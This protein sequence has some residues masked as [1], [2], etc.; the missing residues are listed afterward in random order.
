MLFDHFYRNPLSFLL[1][2]EGHFLEDIFLEK[3]SSPSNSHL[4]IEKTI[5]QFCKDHEDLLK[6]YFPKEKDQKALENQVICALRKLYQY[7]W[8]FDKAFMCYALL[9]K[10]ETFVELY[11]HAISNNET[12]IKVI[13][14]RVRYV[15]IIECYYSWLVGWLV[16]YVS[17]GNIC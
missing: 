14:N 4:L 2:V 9:A 8:L 16:G 12:R 6:T 17:I 15:S 11:E 7:R 3:R 13:L 5:K 1:S 10:R